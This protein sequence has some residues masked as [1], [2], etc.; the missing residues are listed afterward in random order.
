VVSVRSI[1]GRPIPA[2][3]A[4]LTPVARWYR[5]GTRAGG[6]VWAAPLEVVVETPGRALRV[7]RVPDVTRL[8]QLALLTLGGAAAFLLRRRS[9]RRTRR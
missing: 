3:P 4:L 9:P 5:V 2:G 7:V 6:I 8:A 1:A